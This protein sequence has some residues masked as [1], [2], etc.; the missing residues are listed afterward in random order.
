MLNKVLF[1]EKV[2]FFLTERNRDL[3]VLT[4]GNNLEKPTCNF[5]WASGFKHSNVYQACYMCYVLLGWL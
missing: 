2:N 4:S 5:I 3:C 1:I